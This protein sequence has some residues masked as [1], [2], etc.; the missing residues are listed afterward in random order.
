MK[1]DVHGVLNVILKSNKAYLKV[2]TLLDK[3]P[4]VGMN[5][6]YLKCLDRFIKVVFLGIKRSNK[7]NV[8]CVV[9]EYRNS[10]ILMLL[11][12]IYFFKKKLLFLINHNLAHDPKLKLH[13]FLDTIG[14]C[15][16]TIDS[17]LNVDD[18]K[19]FKNKINVNSEIIVKTI[20]SKKK[21][22][23]IF[24]KKYLDIIKKNI[25]EGYTILIPNRNSIS[26][27]EIG[28][29]LISYGTQSQ[30][31]FL[32]MLNNAEIVIIDYD[33]VEYFYRTSGLIWDCMSFDNFIIANDYT[34]FK[35]QLK[36]YD[37]KI[38]YDSID[39]IGNQIY[40]YKKA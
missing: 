4:Q 18:E 25:F 39:E 26:N 5:D 30:E 1:Q 22:V 2:Y 36:N 20:N 16:L 35:N 40:N 21:E 11:P 7:E 31:A 38:F 19:L 32:K 8:P 6:S 34:V 27:K 14:I 10:Q 33:K 23:V 15:F 17:K 28:K 37:K 13:H 12:F 24:S 9:R 3:Y 29:N